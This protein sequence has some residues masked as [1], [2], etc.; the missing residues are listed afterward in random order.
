MAGRFVRGSLIFLIVFFCTATHASIAVPAVV[1]SD[2]IPGSLTFAPGEEREFRVYVQEAF[3]GNAEFGVSP[4]AITGTNAGDFTVVSED[5]SGN[6]FDDAEF[7]TVRLRYDGSGQAA[8]DNEFRVTCTTAAAAAFGPAVVCDG[9]EG[10]LLSL[11]AQIAAVA[12]PLMTP[13][14]TTLLA[15]LMLGFFFFHGLRRPR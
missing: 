9:N 6:N 4:F 3:S 11:F 12:I 8:G 5:C 13:L 2:V 10:F 14:G 15:L 1:A 7:C